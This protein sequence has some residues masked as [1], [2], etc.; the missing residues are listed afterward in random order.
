MFTKDEFQQFFRLVNMS[1]S[2]DQMDRINSRLEMPK[3][4]EAV[5]RPACDKMWAL[6][7]NCGITPAT[8][9]EEHMK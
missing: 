5:G 6:I 7:E 1:G 3:F 2:A 8:L 9:T 4:I